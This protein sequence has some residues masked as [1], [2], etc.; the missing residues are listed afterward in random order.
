MFDK[1]EKLKKKKEDDITKKRDERCIPIVNEIL[2]MIANYDGPLGHVTPEEMQKG[3][4]KLIIDIMGL[5]VEKEINIAEINYINSLIQQKMDHA[6]NWTT[7]SINKNVNLVMDKI[8]G[9]PQPEI[10]L[11]E[12]LDKLK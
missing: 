10:T 9:K 6:K 4:D 1:I 11:K 3:Y 5:Y 12:V 8:W 7:E 2:K